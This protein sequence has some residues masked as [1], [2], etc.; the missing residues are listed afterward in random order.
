MNDESSDGGTAADAAGDARG[1]RKFLV[2]VDDTPECR[3]AARYAAR[4]AGRTGGSLVLLRVIET[5][6]EMSHWIAVEER[7]REE[8][9]LEAGHLLHSLA[10]EINTWADL[11][12]AVAIREG[13]LQDEVLAQIEEDSGI[14]ILVLAAANSPEGPGPLV[15]ALAGKLVGSM[16]IPVT[17]VPGNLDNL[18]IDALTSN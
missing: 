12:P 6:S 3:V 2:V 18:R 7:M 5:R 17:V 14:S 10:S 11:V 9:L 8:A 15:S 4:R 16:K 1:D 13:K